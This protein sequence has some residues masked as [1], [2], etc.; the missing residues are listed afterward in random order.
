MRDFP[1]TSHQ[2][3]N[4]A[5]TV[6]SLVDQRALNDV[7][8]VDHSKVLAG[9]QLLSHLRIDSLLL[10]RRWCSPAL[11]IASSLGCP[12][13]PGPT[14]ACYCVPV[15]PS[16][17]VDQNGPWTDHGGVGA[18]LDQRDLAGSG[19]VESGLSFGVEL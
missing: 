1:H 13:A 6:T 10:C 18:G 15:R 3:L 9:G 2:V 8:D 4:P 17:A 14:T 7:R 19:Q 5:Q 16:G 11:R 12:L